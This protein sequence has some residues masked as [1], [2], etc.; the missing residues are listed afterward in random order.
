MSTGVD[1]SPGSS[2]GGGREPQTVLRVS[3][4]SDWLCRGVGGRGLR[5]TPVRPDA[6]DPRPGL[7]EEQSVFIDVD[8][9]HPEAVLTPMPE[10]LSQQQVG[11]RAGAQGRFPVRLRAVL[12]LDAPTLP[13]GTCCPS[14]WP[15]VPPPTP[16]A[17]P[18]P[19]GGGL[20]SRGVGTW[21]R[22]SWS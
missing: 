5:V 21:A 11:R 10:G 14:S 19:A 3:V 7:E 17:P 9:R 1:V 16:P 12:C 6:L 13:G 18:G 22:T 8:C 15:S 2:L 4:D 20:P